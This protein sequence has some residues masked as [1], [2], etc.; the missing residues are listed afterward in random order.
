MLEI[1]CNLRHIFINVFILRFYM[2]NLIFVSYGYFAF[3]VIFCKYH[4]FIL[5]SNFF[6]KINIL[7]FYV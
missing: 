5:V 4:A 3:M 1:Y 6:Y 7:I 2:L